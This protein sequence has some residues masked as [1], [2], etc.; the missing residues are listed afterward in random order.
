MHHIGLEDL[1][2][3]MFH[4]PRFAMVRRNLNQTLGRNVSSE[5]VVAEML[6][7]KKNWLTISFAI[8]NTERVA[9]GSKKE[10]VIS[11]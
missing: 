2:H 11:K 9:E 8:V 10:V 3:V 4:C 7:L 6:R 5:N 1:E